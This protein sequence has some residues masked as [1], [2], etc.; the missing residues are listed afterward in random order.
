MRK[1][2]ILGVLFSGVGMLAGAQLR[3]A[4]IFSSHMVLQRNAPVNVWGR[5]LPG[6]KLTLEFNG[7]QKITKA[8]KNGRW[9]TTF[10]STDAG[11]PYML[12]VKGK[13]ESIALNDILVGDVWL[14]SG[15]SNMEWILKNAQNGPADIAVSA[16]N[17][18]RH[19]KIEKAVSATP[20]DDISA[21][22]WEPASP[23]TSGNFT[24][25]GYYF[26]RSLQKELNI[27]IGL[28]H[29][30]W[31]GTMVETWISKSGLQSN[32]EFINVASRLPN[33]MEQFEKAQTER[34]KK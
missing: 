6:E 23:A 33:S 20:L 2:I 1:E 28:I 34:I 21:T 16:N 26:A 19:V 5:A 24:A 15:Q 29:S 31:G 32:A 30:S 10:S 18:I 11:G 8:D 27:P 17:N 9:L 13:K 25:V 3:V 7:Q 12:T 4:N 22:E 14:C